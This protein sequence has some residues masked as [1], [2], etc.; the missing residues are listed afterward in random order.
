MSELQ[1]SMT[2]L[3]QNLGTLVNRA[4]YGGGRIVL[5]SHG[6][7]KA[8]IIGVDDLQRLKRSGEAPASQLDRYAQALA[9][10]DQLRERIR[11]W[12]EAH[13][14]EPE[15]SVVTL[16]QLREERDDEIAGLR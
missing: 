7:P 2:E 9:A 15:D 16:R 11:C 3:R 6:Q 13:G 4:A 12:Q 10:A 5:V 8:A 14:V 1:V